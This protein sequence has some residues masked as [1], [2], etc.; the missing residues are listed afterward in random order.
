MEKISTVAAKQSSKLSQ[1]IRYRNERSV[2]KVV[3]RSRLKGFPLRL[4]SPV[5]IAEET[6][7]FLALTVVSFL[8]SAG[9]SDWQFFSVR[10]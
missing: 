5:H 7:T 4:S 8:L 2:H 9:H 10:A 1:P 6:F 3:Q